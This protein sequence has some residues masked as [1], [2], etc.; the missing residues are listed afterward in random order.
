MRP[1]PP[2]Q[3]YPQSGY[4]NQAPRPQDPNQFYNHGA[5]GGTSDSP[6][7][8]NPKGAN[9]FISEHP[10]QASS[11]P[12]NFQPPNHAAGAPFYIGGAEVPSQGGSQPSQAQQQQYPPRDPTPRI[13]SSTKPVAPNSTSPPPAQNFAPYNPQTQQQ[14]MYPQQQQQRPQSTYGAQ[15]LATSVYDSP[16]TPHNPNSF[17]PAP[18]GPPDD[19]NAIQSPS[20]GGPSAPYNAAPSQ[21]S[22]PQYHSYAPPD[23]APPPVPQGQPPQP[24][25]QPQYKPYVPPGASNEPSAPSDYYRQGY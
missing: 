25:S 7:P 9:I 24:P 10:Y 13:P 19:G 14:N 15:E 3:G 8:L 23:Q 21:P 16:I 5:Q 18:G 2:G 11:P 6:H 4:A 17:Y 12:P 22:Q 20:A 1:A